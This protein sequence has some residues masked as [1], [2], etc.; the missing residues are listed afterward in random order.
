MP[1][2]FELNYSYKS[3]KDSFKRWDHQ[4]LHLA[5]SVILSLYKRYF[6]W[7]KGWDTLDYLSMGHNHKTNIADKQNTPK[8]IKQSNASTVISK[9]WQLVEVS[10]SAFL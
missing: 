3:H 9:T 2:Q 5:C 1:A 7:N 4:L 6:Q 10:K 8:T